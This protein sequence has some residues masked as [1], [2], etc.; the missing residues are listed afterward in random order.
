MKRKHFLEK[1]D[2]GAIESAIAAAELT[3]SGE[4]R[5]AVSHRP[6]PDA[7]AAA[8]ALFAKL[9]MTRTR[10]R[11]AVLL[12]IAPESQTFAVIGDE[13]VHARCGQPFWDELAATMGGAFHRGEFTAGLVAGVGRAGALLA[14][15]FPRRPDDTNELSDR[16]I[17][18]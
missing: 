8:Q 12:F 4:I 7:V 11:N 18:T 1:L 13:G 17:A 6:E 3:T 14:E 16:V 9:G 15:H 2:H 5:V 10:E